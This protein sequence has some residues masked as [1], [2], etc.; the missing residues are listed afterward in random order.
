M[1]NFRPKPKVFEETD[2]QFEEKVARVLA[3]PE[4]VVEP[5]YKPEKEPTGFFLPPVPLE[6]KLK[7]E[8]SSDLT[9]MVT[10]LTEK[11]VTRIS[12]NQSMPPESPIR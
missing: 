2:E 1:K 6:T 10:F 4:D 5:P 9:R 7:R 3:P 12:E 8:S 11:E